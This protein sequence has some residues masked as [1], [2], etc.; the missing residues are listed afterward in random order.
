MR[1]PWF[2]EPR[3]RP[4]CSGGVCFLRAPAPRSDWPPA[5]QLEG[6]TGNHQK[7]GAL[8]AEEVGVEIQ[9]HLAIVAVQQA[10]LTSFRFTY[11]YAANFKVNKAAG[12]LYRYVYQKHL[13]LRAHPKHAV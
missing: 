10:F 7:V 8:L 9:H 2:T 1:Q 4:V 5:W 13:A 12:P 6:K 11:F 3:Q